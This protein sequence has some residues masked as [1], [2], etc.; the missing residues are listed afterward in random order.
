MPQKGPLSRLGVSSSGL[1]LGPMKAALDFVHE[2]ASIDLHYFSAVA[3]VGG[4]VDDY[5]ENTVDLS[6]KLR[7]V[8]CHVSNVEERIK[9]DVYESELRSHRLGLESLS[10][11]WPRLHVDLANIIYCYP[12][13]VPWADPSSLIEAV[14][15]SAVRSREICRPHCDRR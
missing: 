5:I 4:A 1:A 2:R 6:T 13:A 12:F 3:Q 14:N 7:D 8:T 11:A 15:S 9:G 10:D